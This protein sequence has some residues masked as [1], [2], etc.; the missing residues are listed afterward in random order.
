MLKRVDRPTTQSAVSKR[1]ILSATLFLGS[2]VLLLF[3]VAEG[4]EAQVTPIASTSGISLRLNQVFYEDGSSIEATLDLREYATADPSLFVILGAASGDYEVLE[5]VQVAPSQY[6]SAGAVAVA[7]RDGTETL[8]DGTLSLDPGEIF[9]AIFTVDPA[10][11]QFATVP[12]DWV[13]DFGIYV[14]PSAATPH[15]AVNPAATLTDDEFDL[16]VGQQPMGTLSGAAGPPVQIALHQLIF[17]P[18]SADQLSEFLDEAGGTVVATDVLPGQNVVDGQTSYL[19]N[20]ESGRVPMEYLG[21]MRSLHGE[22]SVLVGSTTDT[23]ETFAAALY[24][25]MEGY[26]ASVNPRVLPAGRPIPA[27]ERISNAMS[28]GITQIAG[29]ADC[30]P[31]LVAPAVGS[32]PLEVPKIWSHN[33]LWDTDRTEVK[34]A[35]LD[36]GFQVNP[37]FRQP[38]DGSDLQQCDV[39]TVLETTAGDLGEIACGPGEAEGVPTVGN[40]LFGPRSWHGTGVVTVAGG[41]IN[42][43]W[44]STGVGGQLVVPM[45]YETGLVSYAFGLGVATR[46]AV[47]DGADC[48][49]LSGGYPCRL[50]TNVG[51]DFNIC[52]TGGRAALCSLVTANL[53]AVTA[54]ICGT[55]AAVSAIPLV[56]LALGPPLWIACGLSVVATAA[57]STACFA[58]LAAGNL[59]GTMASAIS[60]ART[61]GV[62][63]V[64]IAGNTQ[65]GS[66]IGFD[67]IRDWIDF[68]DDRIERWRVIPGMIPDTITVGAANAFRPFSNN[69]VRGQRIDT[70]APVPVDYWAPQTTD[71]VSDSP[72]SDHQRQGQP[73]GATSGAAP[74]VAGLVASMQAINPSLNRSTP[75]LSAGQLDAIPGIIRSTLRNQSFVQAELDTMIGPTAVSAQMAARERFVAPI[76]TLQ[77]ASSGVLPD[78]AA[79]G[80]DTA[81]NFD[82]NPDATAGDDVPTG[83]P[84]VLVDPGDTIAGT[85]VALRGG[86]RGTV[87]RPTVSDTDT[88]FMSLTDPAPG[89]PAGGLFRGRAV[90]RMPTGDRFGRVDIRGPLQS[91]TPLPSIAE[92]EDRLELITHPLYPGGLADIQ[93]GTVRDEDNLYILTL[94][95]FERIGDQPQADRFDT[96]DSNN[97]TES[98]PDNDSYSRQVPLAAG[99]SGFSDLDWSGPFGSGG[100]EYFEIVIPDL[101]FH[102]VD[103][104]DWFGLFNLPGGAVFEG[105]GCQPELII[106]ADPDADSQD[107]T[108]LVLSSEGELVARGRNEA[109][110]ASGRG[111]A[112]PL[113]LTLSP[114]VPGGYAL[115]DLRLRYARPPAHLCAL[116]ETLEHVREARGT[117]GIPQAFPREYPEALSPP[118]SA[119]PDLIRG[120][121]QAGRV[122]TPDYSLID[123]P[124]DAPFEATVELAKGTSLQVELLSVEGASLALGKTSD[125]MAEDEGLAGQGAIPDGLSGQNAVSSVSP[126]GTESFDLDVVGT[127]AAGQYVIA[128]S[129]G[130][131]GTEFR[132][133]LPA[134]AIT[135]GSPSLE[136]CL[137]GLCGLTFADSDSDGFSD[138][139]DLCPSSLS[140]QQDLDGD[141][142]GDECDNCPLTPNPGQSN[143]DQDG[144][145]DAC[146]LDATAPGALSLIQPADGLTDVV[147]DLIFEWLPGAEAESSYQLQISETPDFSVLTLSHLGVE[148]M[149]SVPVARLAQSKTYYWRVLALAG[150]GVQ[151]EP[152]TLYAVSPTRVFLTASDSG[153]SI[154]PLLV[155]PEQGTI[156]TQGSLTLMWTSDPAAEH[157][158]VQLS[159]DPTFAQIDRSWSSRVSSAAVLPGFV[160]GG[161]TYYWRVESRDDGDVTLSTSAISV[162]VAAAEDVDGDSYPD[163]SDAFPTDRAEWVDTDLDGTGNNADI[164]DDGD[165]LLDSEEISAGTDPLVVDTDGDGFSD[166]V[167]VSQGFDPLDP[168]DPAASVPLLSIPGAYLLGAILTALVFGSGLRRRLGRS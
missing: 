18:R 124:V 151:P 118:P 41:V 131:L 133:R 90:L 160:D 91:I 168:N 43:D 71:A 127:L 47:L 75:G 152:P 54:A 114:S 25:R 96:D 24:W 23:L 86:R 65:S 58:T 77:S 126:F 148:E 156:Q 3:S 53:L 68:S 135:D 162:F 120:I 78:F 161:E 113:A 73:I 94:D 81:L 106:E 104:A 97:P 140:T 134:N 52:T 154:A 108:I 40:S 11:P 21:L 163:S 167:E 16:A 149:Y 145:G 38:A 30:D 39:K 132:I 111:L 12:E 35:I 66:S 136:S 72:L 125:L 100:S 70:W 150:G 144:E 36:M 28:T 121:D 141:G 17:I 80:F 87:D 5:L 15:Q 27:D 48:I 110:V 93:I 13:T 29:G 74:Y 22:E 158:E 165:G 57:A 166:G 64:S 60:F 159:Q 20:V 109:T 6:E 137:N 146:D 107:V 26:L 31:A 122:S 117:G 7:T 1:A 79:R 63:F 50:I 102:D 46:K 157:Y 83:A 138:L 99:L 155:A 164:D 34:M 142:V 153:Q 130:F 92:D 116:A 8:V 44:G 95:G 67:A 105:P 88:I 61:E 14:D 147:S 143:H 49:N 76:R 103:D 42:N 55:A 115:Y 101:N 139:D 82:E 69:Q 32:C 51:P 19:V 37:D 9:S 119:A 62:P 98:R 10:K 56:G 128:V 4:S 59:E 112:A 123:W 85:V 45:L 89:Y 84:S 33:A 2:L 129:R